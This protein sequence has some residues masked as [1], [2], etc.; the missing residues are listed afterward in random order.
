MMKWKLRKWSLAV[1]LLVFVDCTGAVL[2][3]GKPG[4]NSGL[5]EEYIGSSDARPVESLGTGYV[6]L[7][8]KDEDL[9]VVLKLSLIHI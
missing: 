7:D 8:Y 2:A 3:Q 4:S 9:G 6:S 5:F 1:L